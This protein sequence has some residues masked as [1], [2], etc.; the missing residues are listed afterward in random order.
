MDSHIWEFSQGGRKGNINFLP[1]AQNG[2]QITCVAGRRKG[3]RK[4]KMN[5]GGRRDGLQGSYCFRSFFFVHHRARSCDLW[6][7][8]LHLVRWQ[9]TFHF[10]SPVWPPRFQ[11]ILFYLVFISYDS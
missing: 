3:G 8:R 2:V 9:L 5:A 6:S 11:V 1:A 4:A 10:W 7:G